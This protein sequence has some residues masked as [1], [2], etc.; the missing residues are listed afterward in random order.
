MCLHAV[1]MANKM[2]EA[3]V[4][5]Q[6]SDHDADRGC[7]ERKELHDFLAEVC[8][9]AKG[10]EQ[11]RQVRWSVDCYLKGI[12]EYCYFILLHDVAT[13]YSVLMMVRKNN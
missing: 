8:C 9:Q 5:D 7:A 3:T 11:V 2:N 13:I 4:H 12:E 10:L 6:M 1:A